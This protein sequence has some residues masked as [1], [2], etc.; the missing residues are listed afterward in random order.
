MA[1]ATDKPE[2][3]TEPLNLRI[4]PS[5]KKAFQIWCIQNETDM[6]REIEHH[7]ARLL[8]GKTKPAPKPKKK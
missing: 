6:S 1:D 4:T 5:Q 7:I 2:R 8:D 3:R